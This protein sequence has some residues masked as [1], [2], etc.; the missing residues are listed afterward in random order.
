MSFDD[1]KI[2]KRDRL[3]FKLM[4]HGYNDEISR[5]ESI[6]SKNSR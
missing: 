1:E 6:D 4:L 5:N 3:L 2:I